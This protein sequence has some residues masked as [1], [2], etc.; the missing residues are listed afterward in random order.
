MGFARPIPMIF[1]RRSSRPPP[2]SLHPPLPSPAGRGRR[3]GQAA[4][5]DRIAARM[6][7]F[8]GPRQLLD[9]GCGS[10]VLSLRLAQTCPDLRITGLESSSDQVRLA[11]RA[12]G[13][14]GLASRLRF[15]RSDLRTFPVSDR[16]FDLVVGAGLL[17][18]APSP[19]SLLSE[20]SRVLVP[21]GTAL[22]L[23]PVVESEAEAPGPSSAT[24]RRP[25]PLSEAHVRRL[26]SS[27]PLARSSRLTRL[28]SDD[29][30]AFL[31]IQLI[32]PLPERE[33]PRHPYR[34]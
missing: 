23:E 24:P 20:V 26:V 2:G 4:L 11:T 29:D 8:P 34:R 31:E 27:C 7:E 33:P 25:G 9:L 15:S 19:Q 10:G 6:S 30:L 13:E 14:A 32:A 21:G 1:R 16:S 5:F 3:L 28:D 22:L 12:A 17:S 18:E